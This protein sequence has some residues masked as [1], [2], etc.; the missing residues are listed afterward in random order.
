[1]KR[2]HVQARCTV[3]PFARA[4]TGALA[5]MRIAPRR[6]EHPDPRARRPVCAQARTRVDSPNQPDPL[7]PH[8]V[9]TDAMAHAPQNAGGHT[10]KCPRSSA[11]VRLLNSGRISPR[12]SARLRLWSLGSIAARANAR[13]G[14]WAFPK[15]EHRLTGKGLPPIDVR[16]SLITH[17]NPFTTERDAN[18]GAT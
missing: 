11:T 15:G 7:L 10:P 16:R 14:L 5:S 13:T 18:E 8:R 6:S 2:L 1:M 12:A 4:I 17:R 9:P 3:D